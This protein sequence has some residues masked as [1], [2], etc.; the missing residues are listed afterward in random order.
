[1]PDGKINPAGNFVTRGMGEWKLKPGSEAQADVQIRAVEAAAVV[2]GLFLAAIHRV[3]EEVGFIAE[4]DLRIAVPSRGAKIAAEVRDDDASGTVDV[5]R[6]VVDVGASDTGKSVEAR[7]FLIQMRLVNTHLLLAE[8]HGNIH[9]PIEVEFALVFV[10]QDGLARIPG[11]FGADTVEGTVFVGRRVVDVAVFEGQPA[12][13]RIERRW[14]IVMRVGIEFGANARGELRHPYASAEGALSIVSEQADADILAEREIEHHM[15]LGFPGLRID[16]F[17]IECLERA[18]PGFRTKRLLEIAATDRGGQPEIICKERRQDNIACR[19][20]RQTFVQI[21]LARRTAVADACFQRPIGI[22]GPDFDIA[23][24]VEGGSGSFLRDCGV[25]QACRHRRSKGRIEFLP[26]GL[27]LREAAAQRY[28]S[29]R[30]LA[31]E[32]AKNVTA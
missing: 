26:I 22:L 25:R 19:H 24:P 5:R 2:L 8:E 9:A 13:E 28:P 7:A 23:F 16:E 1:M 27:K 21:F 10:A 6:R 15:L 14:E 29:R 17:G 12:T 11:D 3:E 4:I 30:V 20:Y 18:N 31:G 32:A